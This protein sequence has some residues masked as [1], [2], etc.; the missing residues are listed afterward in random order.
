MMPSNQGRPIAITDHE[1]LAGEVCDIV[2]P[3]QTA[4]PQQAHKPRSERAAGSELRPTQLTQ[5]AL[6]PTQVPPP[7][8]HSLKP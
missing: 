3:F 7:A 1:R 5:Q 2:G 8:T 4:G 6:D